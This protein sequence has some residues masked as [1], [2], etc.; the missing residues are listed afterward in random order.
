[1]KAPHTCVVKIQSALGLTCCGQPA[2]NAG[3]R[4][5]ARPV[6]ARSDGPVRRR[7][8]PHPDAGHDRWHPPLPRLGPDQGHRPGHR[9]EDHRHLRQVHPRGDRGRPRP[10]ASPCERAGGAAT[11]AAIVSASSNAAS[12]QTVA[13]GRSPRPTIASVVMPMSPF[14]A[15]RFCA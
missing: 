13:H 10:P 12:V 8:L 6:A 1:M 2:Y 4:S 7:H 3:L 14:P 9:E 11:I 15:W 5:A